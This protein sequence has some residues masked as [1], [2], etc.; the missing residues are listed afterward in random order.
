MNGIARGWRAGLSHKADATRHSVGETYENCLRLDS[1]VAFGGKTGTIR[2]VEMSQCLPRVR[3]AESPVKR[4]RQAK[5]QVKTLLKQVENSQEQHI[6]Q[7]V[8]MKVC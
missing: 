3:A 6:T 4:E 7:L 5:A 8:L 1:L 2:P